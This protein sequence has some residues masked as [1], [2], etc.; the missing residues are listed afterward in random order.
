ML[1]GKLVDD[2]LK[3][4]LNQD[5][6]EYLSAIKQ[7]DSDNREKYGQNIPDSIPKN[8]KDLHDY[9]MNRVFDELRKVDIVSTKSNFSERVK[10]LGIEGNNELIEVLSKQL[11]NTKS[12]ITAKKLKKEI[13][14]RKYYV[15]VLIKE[16][17]NKNYLDQISELKEKGLKNN[18][19]DYLINDLQEKYR[20]GVLQLIPRNKRDNDNKTEYQKLV[21]KHADVIQLSVKK[22]NEEIV[23]QKNQYL[24]EWLKVVKNIKDPNVQI[25]LKN[26]GL[27]NVNLS[28]Y[29]DLQK[30]IMQAKLAIKDNNQQYANNVS[31]R[32]QKNGKLFKQLK[33]DYEQL[34]N[35]NSKID[36]NQTQM[37]LNQA[38]NDKHVSRQK[39]KSKSLSK[40]ENAER[41]SKNSVSPRL[42]GK[43]SSALTSVKKEGQE[44]INALRRNLDKED[45]FEK[46]D[47]ID[48]IETE[49]GRSMER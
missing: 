39:N 49:T 14:I 27:E 41:K 40:K 9:L 28:E 17:K 3:T 29:V 12:D 6:E 10:W 43:L 35:I 48:E 25:Y 20:L 47:R 37:R 13:G 45:D 18:V 23:A 1:T 2:F 44:R 46:Q 30:R 26:Q 31:L 11:K 15:G 8:Q 16:N 24:D 33:K 21:N 4:D 38:S 19:Q 42:L 5:Y 22:I 32:N 36:L 34:K 7:K